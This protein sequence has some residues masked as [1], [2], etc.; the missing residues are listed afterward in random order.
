MNMLFFIVLII[1]HQLLI[2]NALT[3]NES[4][5]FETSR[6]GGGYNSGSRIWNH[7]DC[8]YNYM[9]CIHDYRPTEYC[10]LS[11]EGCSHT[12]IHFGKGGSGIETSVVESGEN[13]TLPES[14]FVSN[15]TASSSGSSSSS[16]FTQNQTTIVS[17]SSAYTFNERPL[18][19]TS[20]ESISIENSQ[21]GVYE[22]DFE[23][24]K[25]LVYCFWRG[26]QTYT[27]VQRRGQ[28]SS[29]YNYFDKNWKD[30]RNGFG[31]PDKEHWLGLDYMTSLMRRPQDLTILLFDENIKKVR[32]KLLN[33]VISGRNSS[34]S[35]KYDA[36]IAFDE[37][38]N[39]SITL[40][41]STPISGLKF[42]TRDKN[43]YPD[44]KNCANLFTGGWWFDPFKDCGLSNLNGLNYKGKYGNVTSNG[45]FWDSFR[46]KYYSLLISRMFV[47]KPRRVAK[48]AINLYSE[49]TL[50]RFMGQ[51]VFEQTHGLLI[52]NGKVV[53]LTSGKHGAAIVETSSLGDA[54]QGLGKHFNPSGK[55]HGSPSAEDRHEGDLGNII[56]YDEK[57]VIEFTFVSDKLSIKSI[58]PHHLILGR[59]FVIYEG[60][61][62]LGIGL[63]SNSKVDGNVGKP[64]ACGL[65]QYNR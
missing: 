12:K 9:I 31:E 62:D 50:R 61:D 25:K 5:Y 55:N 56:V 32:I 14:S 38:K 44:Q 51:V 34:F 45:I 49:S 1:G 28:F 37:L 48:L 27:I 59:T 54:C 63:S 16:E 11:L 17:S 52:M 23:G 53:S 13:S 60:E 40:P 7:V 57:E 43:S 10:L 2:C 46:G 21:D 39:R 4:V 41:K 6:S 35:L 30:Y 3:F 42:S 64:V 18:N 36:V 22:I 58:S 24:N 15:G 47:S 8:V 29:P 19:I 20:C 65:V 26:N 33:A